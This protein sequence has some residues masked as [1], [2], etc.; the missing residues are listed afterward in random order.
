MNWQDEGFILSKKIV[1]NAIILEVFTNKF[2]GV[3]GIV[4]GGTSRKL[5]YLQLSNKIFLIYNLKTKIELDILKRTCRS[6]ASKYFDNK[7]ILCL[8]SVS[9]FVKNSS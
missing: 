8:N 3:N 4:Y 9:L 2:G 6:T 1:K 5:K 7:K